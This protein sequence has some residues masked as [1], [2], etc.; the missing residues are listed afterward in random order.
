M[1][2]YLTGMTKYQR[3]KDKLEAKGDPGKQEVIRKFEQKIEQ[4]QN[5]PVVKEF[6]QLIDKAQRIE[7]EQVGE[8]YASMTVSFILKRLAIPWCA[9]VNI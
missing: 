9:F 4:T 3:L 1:K 5:I 7:P 2:W 6:I 8:G